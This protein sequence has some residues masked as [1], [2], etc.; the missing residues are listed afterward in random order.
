[1]AEAFTII[2]KLS[3][4]GGAGNEDAYGF[5]Q[6]DDRLDVWIVDGATSIAEEEHLGL[7]I[8]DP[9]WF[10]QSINAAL[11]R[12][13]DGGA[14]PMEALRE[15]IVVTGDD[16][17][18]RVEGKKIPL[19]E[20]PLASL[21]WLRA[22]AAAERT[23]LRFLAMGD[24][25]FLIAHKNF[26]ELFPLQE[27]G[28][29]VSVAEDNT[30]T[31]RSRTGVLLSHLQ[32]EKARREQYHTNPASGIVGMDARAVD[33]ARRQVTTVN[34]PFDILAMSDG[35]YRLVDEYRLYE[36]GGLYRA[37]AE[38]GLPALYQQLRAHE[39]A[40]EQRG[41]PSVKRRDDATAIHIHHGL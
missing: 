20:K 15:A 23:E 1:M 2:D 29:V 28:D 6:Q 26:I 8:S 11:G 24:S 10:A 25:R 5:H 40:A 21:V 7:D 17:A 16:Y 18:R 14:D 27:R 41:D 38:K 39:D 3:E 37:A 13:I 4:A 32:G 30:D 9:A 33:Y 35:F 31:A 36:D 12:Y 34:G 22:I 19:Y